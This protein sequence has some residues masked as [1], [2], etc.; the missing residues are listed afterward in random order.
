MS[1][2]I[3]GLTITNLTA[4]PLGYTSEDVSLGLAARSWT[5]AGLL[6]ST[7]LGQFISI[8]ETWLAARRGDADS[9]ASN[10][11]G[12]TVSLSF[13]ANG[14]SASGVACWFTDA[15]SI[16]QVGAYVQLT[17]TL[18]DA[19]QAL[20]VAKKALE[21]SSAAD[22]ALLPSLG[23]VT[24]GGGTITLSALEQ[25]QLNG[26]NETFVGFTDGQLIGLTSATL[27]NASVLTA[28]DANTTILRAD[29]ALR[30]V[31]G[32]RSDFGAVQNRFEST[33]ANLTTVSE[34]LEA[35]R[36]RI[37]DADFAAETAALTRAQIL[38]QAGTA[39]IAQANAIP[40]NVL[41]LL[42]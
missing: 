16:E 18:V 27:N 25:I 12:S 17:A 21:K 19:N 35:S 11:V 15:P 20:T 40:Q 33:I 8:F 37:R 7:Q 23:T 28:A 5:V 36:S 34:N 32:L 4:Q 39:M 10:S 2:T 3:N 41:T 1:V 24:L 29:A 31:S 22:D 42:R 14:L 13:S 9:I 38:Q 26:A 6:N 30:T